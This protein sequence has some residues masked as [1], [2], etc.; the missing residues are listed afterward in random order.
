MSVLKKLKSIS[1]IKYYLEGK[2]LLNNE[3]YQI[4]RE[5]TKLESLKIPSRTEIINYILSKASGETTYL[6]IGVRN[7][8]R[9]FNHIIANK[10]YGVDPGIKFKKNPVD[11]KMTSD[12]FFELLASNKVLSS[13]IKFDLIFIDG[14]HLAEQVDKDITNSMKYIKDD[15]FI[16]LHD[17]NPPTEWHARENQHYRNS[18][19]GK[20]WNG[21]T[22]KAFLKWRFNSTVNS[23]CIDSD[24]GVGILSKK[25]LIGQSIKESNQFFE[26][27]NLIKNKYEYLNLISFNDFKGLITQK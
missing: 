14:S 7:P 1:F 20:S 5:K 4:G 2:K 6:E 8:I 16:V 18:P 25:R 27:C 13:E 26:H 24:C 19:A 11:Y 21:T 3:C 15:G 23:C 9:N 10:K 17:C 12:E 22:W